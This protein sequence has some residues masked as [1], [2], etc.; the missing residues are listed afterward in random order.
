MMIARPRIQPGRESIPCKYEANKSKENNASKSL[1][2]LRLFFRIGTFQWVASEKIKNQSTRVSSCVRN[3]SSSFLLSPTSRSLFSSTGARPARASIRRIGIYVARFPFFVK[4]RSDIFFVLRP[5]RPRKRIAA[6]SLL[7]LGRIDGVG[8]PA[9]HSPSRD[10]RP[11][12]RPMWERAGVGGRAD[13]G[14]CRMRRCS[15]VA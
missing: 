6:W 9:P 1:A 8:A 13:Q 2:L 10:G 3:V 15:L 5:R 4:G 11:S 7:H 12:G 14:D